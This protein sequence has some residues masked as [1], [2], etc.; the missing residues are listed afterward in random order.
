[1]TLKYGTIVR[2]V[3]LI[4]LIAHKAYTLAIAFRLGRIVLIAIRGSESHH[5]TSCSFE[6]I[7]E[8]ASGITI[9]LKI[10]MQRKNK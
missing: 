1:M 8:L 6:K 10:L 4:V 9:V 7:V 5:L 2:H 3:I